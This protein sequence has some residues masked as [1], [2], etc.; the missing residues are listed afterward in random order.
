MENQTVI[1][2]FERIVADLDKE[3]RDFETKYNYT[4]PTEEDRNKILDLRNKIE[5]YEL[6]IRN[7][8]LADIIQ[9]NER[10][11]NMEYDF[12]VK[13]NASNHHLIYS[14]VDGQTPN[15]SD[16][17]VLFGDKNKNEFT[18][19]FENCDI[20]NLT[21]KTTPMIRV[22]LFNRPYGKESMCGK[23][24]YMGEEDEPYEKI[25]DDYYVGYAYITKAM[26]DEALKGTGIS[27][28]TY[29]VNIGHNFFDDY[30]D[31]ETYGIKELFQNE[32]A[33][34]A[35]Y[36][37][38]NKEISYML[39]FCPETIVEED[40]A[41]PTEQMLKIAKEVAVEY[42]DYADFI[43]HLLPS[44]VSVTNKLNNMNDDRVFDDVPTADNDFIPLKAL[45]EDAL[46][47]GKNEIFEK[48]G[49]GQICVKTDYDTILTV[50]DKMYEYIRK[51]LEEELQPFAVRPWMNF[52]MDESKTYAEETGQ[53]LSWADGLFQAD[54]LY[55]RAL[56]SVAE[57]PFT[58]LMQSKS[59]F[60]RYGTMAEYTY[61]P[62]YTPVKD[63]IIE[64]V[65]DEKLP[66]GCETNEE[67]IYDVME[68]YDNLLKGD[69][70]NGRDTI[71]LAIDRIP[72]EDYGLDE[73]DREDR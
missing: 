28:Q 15:L 40:N 72:L 73:N 10:K 30:K 24:I 35:I 47:N 59:P 18:D 49:Y 60:Q 62:L 63:L 45:Y 34:K 61:K 29:G 52:I 26:I 70:P 51:K 22:E 31:F 46:K 41:K 7:C 2:T 39:A 32:T 21:E 12:Y 5:M 58:R 38:L 44:E 36:D 27:P 67:Y 57:E 68:E 53:E 9:S 71:L 55:L 19:F 66:S 50:H 17:M 6:A 42:V 37:Y 65:E 4:V 1:R 43:E 16:Y 13:S 25:D 56:N 20:L 69:R 11:I 64:L 8:K 48:N 14:A 23:S 3:L 33:V 54:N